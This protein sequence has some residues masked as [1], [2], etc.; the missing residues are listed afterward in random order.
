MK[1]NQNLEPKQASNYIN[2]DNVLKQ[3]CIYN[4]KENRDFVNKILFYN[5][6]RSLRYQRNHF[7][8]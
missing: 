3:R 1:T 7:Q 5:K 6:D 2:S 4:S 8:R